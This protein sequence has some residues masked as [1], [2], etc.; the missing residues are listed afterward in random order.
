MEVFVNS[1]HV[2]MIKN[3]LL[4]GGIMFVPLSAASHLWDGSHTA[5]RRFRT[6]SEKE[7]SKID[8]SF[9]KSKP[10]MINMNKLLGDIF[11]LLESCTATI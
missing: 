2:N 3:L 9:K 5:A 11:V 1:F 10:E 7:K 6:S 8:E 4:H